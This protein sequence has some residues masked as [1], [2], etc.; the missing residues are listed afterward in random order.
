MFGYFASALLCAC[1]ARR[2]DPRTHAPQRKAWWIMVLVL[3]LLGINKQLDLQGLLMDVG[4]AFAYE[5]GVYE[6]RRVLQIIFLFVLAATALAVMVLWF[7]MNRHSWR[8]EG[9]MLAGS[10]FL[11]TFVLVRAASFHHFQEFFAVPL[12]GVRLHRVVE[13]F[14][15][16]WVAAAAVMRLSE[17]R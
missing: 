10:V 13:L 16:A 2:F 9:P 5:E 8:E 14:A 12:G 1:V 3:V 6:K 4:R 15:I 11:V 7:R 17:L